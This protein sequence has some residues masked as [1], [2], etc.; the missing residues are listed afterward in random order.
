VAPE[1]FGFPTQIHVHHLDWAPLSK[2][3]GCNCAGEPIRWWQ[4]LLAWAHMIEERM[5][6]CGGHDRSGIAEVE[7]QR[8]IDTVLEHYPGVDRQQVVRI[9]ADDSAATR[10]QVMR[11]LFCPADDNA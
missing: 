7:M 1:A 5:P 11:S 3:A 8:M 4:R 10:Q 6:F 9:V 2:R